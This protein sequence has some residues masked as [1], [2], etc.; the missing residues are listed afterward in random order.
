MSDHIKVA[1]YLLATAAAIVLG[2]AVAY[3]IV[4]PVGTTDRVI[5][6]TAVAAAVAFGMLRFR[7]TL[8]T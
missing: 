6:S 5:I 8:Y 4:E 1:S 3:N 2:I 7:V